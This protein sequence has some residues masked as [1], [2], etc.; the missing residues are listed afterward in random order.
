[1]PSPGMT[2][3]RKCGLKRGR[4][5]IAIYG[6]GVRAGRTAR[7]P[8]ARSVQRRANHS[9]SKGLK[10]PPLLPQLQIVA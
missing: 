4:A 1:M 3:T 2:W 10:A 7:Q 9:A 5:S 8:A 6:V